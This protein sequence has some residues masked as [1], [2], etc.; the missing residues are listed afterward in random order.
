MLR[1]IRVASAVLF[2]GA[3]LLLF[4]DFTGLLQRW[5]GWVADIQF[6]PAL[7]SLNL[8]VVVVAVA[9]TFVFGRIYCSVICPLGIFQDVVSHLS[10]SRKKHR[11]M[12]KYRKERSLV[13][14][15]FLVLFIITLV[16]GIPAIF[17][18]L[19]PYSAFGRIVSEI[20]APVYR[21]VNNLFADIAQRADSY[22][23]YSREVLFKGFAVLGISV[24]TLVVVTIFAWREGR[25]YCNT[26]CPVGTILGTI[27]RFSLFRPV[28]DSSKCTKCKVCEKRC[29]SC[30][31]DSNSH[32]IDMSRCVVCF[33]CLGNCKS[34]AISYK[35]RPLKSIPLKK[36]AVNN[37]AVNKT[38]EESAGDISRRSFISLTALLASSAMLKAQKEKVDGGLA[39][40]E[41]KRQPDRKV[42]VTPPGSGGYRRLSDHCTA[43]Q[44]CITSCPSDIL[45]PSQSLDRF[46][47]PYMT[48]EN[49]YCRPE[50]TRC[51]SLCPTGAIKKI[52][53][54]EKSAVHIGHAVWLEENCLVAKGMRCGN[55][56]KHCPAG[57]LSYTDG[58]IA[59]DESRC[60]GCGS[61]E[62]HCPSR[63]YSAIYVEGNQRHIV[64]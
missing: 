56:V 20:F 52:D 26:V 13:R 24:V 11:Y 41:Q 4:L 59:V 12:F 32:K 40:I 63:P 64:E 1:K 46:M 54:A 43:C 21:L 8:V 39:V 9:I 3:A 2:F 42:P 22:L 51:S 62:Y 53:R 33:D 29:K 45:R 5:L 25:G 49:G 17:T 23:F 61:C 15:G 50:C 7:L 36:E 48:F 38:A 55:C 58:G 16:A 27:S 35:L 28:I 60:I 44:L 57:A 37:S 6:I 10:T 47:Q 31:I 34:G 14:Y 19:E 30:A 18:L